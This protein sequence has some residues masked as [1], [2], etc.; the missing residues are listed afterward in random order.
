MRLA[1]EFKRKAIHAIG[2]LTPVFFEIFGKQFL[3]LSVLFCLCFSSF[4]EFLRLKH[5]K[6]VFYSKLLRSYEQDRLAGYVFFLIGILTCVVIFESAVAMAA[7]LMLA[8]GDGIAGVMKALTTGRLAALAMFVIS[9]AVGCIYLPLPVSMLGAVGATVA[10]FLPLHLRFLDDN[11][12][13][14]L[15]SATLMQLSLFLLL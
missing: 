7:I 9:T 15:F 8:A 13:I 1:S 3:I 2:I 4:F 14:P 6:L 11:L 10:D 5:N 12:L